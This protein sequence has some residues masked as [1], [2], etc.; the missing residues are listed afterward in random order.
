MKPCQT[1]PSTSGSVTLASAPSASN[2]HSSTFSAAS[3]NTAKFVPEPSYVA[4]SGYALP[5]QISDWTTWGAA[6]RVKLH[7][8]DGTRKPTNA[9]IRGS[10]GPILANR[11]Y[12]LSKT[13]Q[14]A[15]DRAA[16]APY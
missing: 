8:P 7:T 6:A 11:R 1:K 3:L 12:P 10:G 16:A 5:G 9:T 14:P 4:P 13:C 15:E 2:R